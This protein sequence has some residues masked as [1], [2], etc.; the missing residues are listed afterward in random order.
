MIWPFDGSTTVFIIV[1]LG[2]C[3][4]VGAW[5]RRVGADMGAT[6]LIT[7]LFSPLVGALYVLGTTSGRKCPHC[8][9]SVDREATVCRH[10]SR[11]LASAVAAP[12]SWRGGMID[13]ALGSRQPPSSPTGICQN[14]GRAVFDR[15]AA[16]CANCGA[17]LAGKGAR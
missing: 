5:A 10:C 16:S 15:S 4:G 9:G 7:G 3:Y 2:M 11:D 1:W 12:N 13:R 17:A 14:C 8:R 6:I